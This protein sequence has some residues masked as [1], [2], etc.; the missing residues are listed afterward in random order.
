M[1]AAIES[2][3]LTPRRKLDKGL[4]EPRF[5]RQKV[6]WTQRRAA[7]ATRL[8]ETYGYCGVCAEDAINYVTHIL[9]NRPVL[10]TPKSEGIEWQWELHPTQDE[11]P[12][13]ASG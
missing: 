3:L 12:A 4:T 11:T 6:E 7:I 10:R 13:N 2:R 1:Q 9:K 5:A 8:T